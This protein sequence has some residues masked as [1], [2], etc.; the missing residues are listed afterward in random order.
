MLKLSDFMQKDETSLP[1]ARAEKKKS[2][3][4]LDALRDEMNS[5]F[6]RFQGSTQSYFSDWSIPRRSFVDIVDTGDGY[7]LETEMPGLEPED[8]TLETDGG[9]LTIKG[10]RSGKKEEHGKKGGVSYLRNEISSAAFERSISLPARADG[11]KAAATLRNGLLAVTM[12]KK[13]S[14]A[15]DGAKKMEIRKSA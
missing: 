8:I 3:S 10:A 13:A 4:S 15:Q 9:T 2:R 12:P 7:R 5:L 14:V 11:E 6:D 1:V